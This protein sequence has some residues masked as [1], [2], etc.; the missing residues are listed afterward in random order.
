MGATEQ[1][2]IAVRAAK[3]EAAKLLVETIN[4][5]GVALAKLRADA[6]ADAARAAEQ[7]AGLMREIAA[8]ERTAAETAR[9]HEAAFAAQETELEVRAVEQVDA[10]V[11]AAQV[12]A[13]LALA[14]ATRQQDRMVEKV[15]TDTRADAARVTDEVAALKRQLVETERATEETTRRSD[16]A[17]A[18]VRANLEAAEARR[19]QLEKDH[20]AEVDRV[21]R[22]ADAAASAR[23][24]GLE[25]EL[26][27]RV[28]ERAAQ[29]A[30]E[31]HDDAAPTSAR[32]AERAMEVQAQA[33]A[34][35]ARA[36]ER[37]ASAEQ[38]LTAVRLEAD[39]ARA[40][41]V[42]MQV[43]WSDQRARHERE[44]AALKIR[45]HATHVEGDEP[46]D[47]TRADWRATPRRRMAEIMGGLVL[48]GCTGGLIG[49]FVSLS[50]I[51]S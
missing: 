24:A 33:R 17:L 43:D 42:R 16:A 9:Q 31:S 32:D 19:V 41:V 8:A 51:L 1:V 49:W 4:Q 5:H 23:I 3:E 13:D 29:V 14:E 45:F 34:D 22:E 48:A 26:E 20:A 39:Q 11:R 7:V 46:A 25:T 40:E 30:R 50:R 35:V 47:A 2:E 38:A 10:A 18:D 12:E 37:V 36:D 28:T 21:R 6:H 15:R 44:I 27:T